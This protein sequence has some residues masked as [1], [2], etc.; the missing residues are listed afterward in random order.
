MRRAGLLLLVVAAAALAGCTAPDESPSQNL[1]TPLLV[2]DRTSDN[3]TTFYVHSAFTSDQLYDSITLALDNATVAQADQ[4]YALTYKTNRTSFF[5]GVDVA[6]GQDRFRYRAR[7]H[8]NA[9]ADIVGVADW[10]AETT[11]LDQRTNSTLPFK[12]VVPSY[13]PKTVEA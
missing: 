11:T 13:E 10:N 5:L 6:D 2:L 8:L 3:N 12:K 7:L 4:T 9:S 1:R